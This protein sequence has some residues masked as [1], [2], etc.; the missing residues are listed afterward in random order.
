M[1]PARWE[2]VWFISNEASFSPA[3]LYAVG[4]AF[5]GISPLRAIAIA[6][7]KGIAQEVRFLARRNRQA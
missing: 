3:A 7:L 4:A 1:N 6:I 5:S 2:T